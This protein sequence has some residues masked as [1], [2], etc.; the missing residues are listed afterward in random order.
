[1][2][3]AQPH[4]PTYWCHPPSPP[5]QQSPEPP[6]SRGRGSGL[7]KGARKG[8]GNILPAAGGHGLGP[9]GLLPGTPG[10]AQR[11]EHPPTHAV[12]GI[13]SLTPATR[14]LRAGTSSSSSCPGGHIPGARSRRAPSP[15]PRCPPSIPAGTCGPGAAAGSG[16]QL[17]EM[18]WSKS[19]CSS[20]RRPLSGRARSSASLARQRLR[21]PAGP[22]SPD[23]PASPGPGGAA[24]AEPRP[25]AMATAALPGRPRYG[26]AEGT[27]RPRQMAVPARLWD[28][29]G[30]LCVQSHTHTGWESP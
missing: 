30:N 18:S 29:S 13:R 14:V 21:D 26:G 3:I 1:M 9:W 28:S 6:R 7:G 22:G 23:S 5:G 17:S 11:G 20:V 4:S 10:V 8:C 2:K 24:M 12:P 27:A 16:P 19:R 25:A 15:Q